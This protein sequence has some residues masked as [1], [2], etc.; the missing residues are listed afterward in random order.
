MR[1]SPDRPSWRAALWLRRQ[2]IRGRR[3]FIWRWLVPRFAI[4]VALLATLVRA[5]TEPFAWGHFLLHVGVNVLGAG[6]VGG[7][8][9]GML[10]WEL[11]VA[12]RRRPERARR[13]PDPHRPRRS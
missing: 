11:I 9:A 3:H 2:R 10:L 6:V 7:Y 13:R 12:G 1:L 8:I 5:L 4:P